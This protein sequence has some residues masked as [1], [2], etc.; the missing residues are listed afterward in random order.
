MSQK[1]QGVVDQE[2]WFS[3]PWASGSWGAKSPR[4]HRASCL[5]TVYFK[6]ISWCRLLSASLQERQ[7][8]LVSDSVPGLF[9]EKCLWYPPSLE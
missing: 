3:S 1:L 9:E 8:A 7:A 5:V 6:L 4:A 2:T